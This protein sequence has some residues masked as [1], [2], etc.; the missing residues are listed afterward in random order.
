MTLSYEIAVPAQDGVWSDEQPQPAQEIVGQRG[1]RSGEK[2]PILGR[3]SHPG[4]IAELSLQ[5]G[6]LVTPGENLDLLVPIA[7]GEQPQRGE[8]VRDGQVGQAKVHD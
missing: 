6:D 4:V 3:E 8:G 5:N 2:G 7:Q 1:Q